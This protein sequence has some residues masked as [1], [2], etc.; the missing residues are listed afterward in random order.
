MSYKIEI[1][2]NCSMPDIS[3]FLEMSQKREK[4]T[5]KTTRLREK[6]FF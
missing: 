3:V 4:T 5:R 1:C 2:F 6:L